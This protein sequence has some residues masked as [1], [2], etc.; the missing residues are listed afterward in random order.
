MRDGGGYIAQEVIAEREWERL[1]ALGTQW[2][3]ARSTAF[4]TVIM[5]GVSK[6]HN[7]LPISAAITLP[8]ISASLVRDLTPAQEVAGDGV[9][10]GKRMMT[11][12]PGVL[13]TSAICA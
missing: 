4:L 7:T 6:L 5:R 12:N 11:R 13:S 9:D 2:D 10:F 3:Q 8:A 1:D